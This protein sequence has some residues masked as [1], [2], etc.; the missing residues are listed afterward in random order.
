MLQKRSNNLFYKTLS[1][2]T[3]FGAAVMLLLFSSCGQK[4]KV[5]GKAITERDSLPIMNTQ[6]VN[7]LISD[8]GI[9]RYRIKTEEWL[10]FDR[11]RP[12]YWAF[13]KGVYLEQFDS[14]L[15]VQASIQADTAYY[16]DRERLWKLTGHVKIMNRKGER[17]NTELLFWNEITQQVYSDRKIRIEQADKIVY[18]CGF[19]AN[20]DMT[21]WNLHNV[22]NTEF[23]FDEK[24]DVAAGSAARKDSVK[25]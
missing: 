21:K 9:T 2:T 22:Y 14:L 6:G 7:T 8:S 1:I 18:A 10:I 19:E 3:A 17:F 13:E 5:L 24:S 23:Y 20:Q 11:K 12:S 25:K 16:Y 15:N 4:D